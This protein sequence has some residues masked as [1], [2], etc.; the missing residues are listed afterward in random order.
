MRGVDTEGHA[1]RVSDLAVQLG[2]ALGV[3]GE[4]LK[5]L[6]RGALLHDIGKIGVSD[7]VLH[8]PGNLDDGD[9]EIIRQVPTHAYRLLSSIPFLRAAIEIPY[10]HHEKWDGSGYPRGLREETIPFAARLFA[11]VDVWDTLISDRPYRAALA[12]S[13]A[14]G[15][16][17]SQAGKQFDPD[18]VAAFLEMMSGHETDLPAGRQA[19]S[20][21]VLDSD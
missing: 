16:I 15:Y 7:A 5:S 21:A 2:R 10:C 19:V 11:V 1:Q 8:K 12:R 17:A 9:W 14:L 20:E 4:N 3:E 6:R 18:V 13:E